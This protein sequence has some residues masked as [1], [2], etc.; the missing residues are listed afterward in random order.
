[1]TTFK[2]AQILVQKEFANKKDKGGNPY[3]CHL[4]YVASH[5]RNEEEKIIGLLH[6]L[7]EDT[8]VTIEELKEMGFSS[9]IL[10]TLKLLTRNKAYSYDEYIDKIINSHNESALYI[11]KIDLEHNMDFT[12]CPNLDETTREKLLKKYTQNYSKICAALKKVSKE[13]KS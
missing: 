8:K 7:L 10:E 1:M 3:L 11:K 4:E 5:G 13:S 6:D 2:T 12:R 9:F